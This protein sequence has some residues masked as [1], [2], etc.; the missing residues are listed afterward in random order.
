LTSDRSGAFFFLIAAAV[1]LFL[2]FHVAHAYGVVRWWRSRKHPAIYQ[3]DRDPWFDIL[4]WSYFC[5]ALAAAGLAIW[6]LVTT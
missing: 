5:G 3:R 1:L 4:K 6:M 2:Q